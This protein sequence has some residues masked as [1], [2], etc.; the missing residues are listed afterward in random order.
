M[1]KTILFYF[2]A[3]MADP[4]VDL[5]LKPEYPSSTC[6]RWSFLEKRHVSCYAY[7]A[8]SSMTEMCMPGHVRNFDRGMQCFT[9]P[10]YPSPRG[11]MGHPPKNGRLQGHDDLLGILLGGDRHQTDFEG[12]L[13]HDHREDWI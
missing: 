8:C 7:H 2:E 3:K 9:N 1:P 10:D 12:T 5:K 4:R 13:E 6:H 11:F